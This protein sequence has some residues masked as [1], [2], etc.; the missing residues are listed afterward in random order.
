MARELGRVLLDRLPKIGSLRCHRP[1]A[2]L[3]FVDT[4][5]R[6]SVEVERDGW[7]QYTRKQAAG[8]GRRR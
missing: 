6:V 4:G 3:G 2:V 1:G 7:L 5:D 8:G